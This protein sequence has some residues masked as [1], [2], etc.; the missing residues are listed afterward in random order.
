MVQHDP[1][2]VRPISNRLK[3]AQ[4][5]LAAVIRALDRARFAI[6]ATGLKHCIAKDG[7][8]SLETQKIKKLLLSLA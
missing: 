3:R 7:A 2:G 8:E 5:Q 1:D 6:V 4:G